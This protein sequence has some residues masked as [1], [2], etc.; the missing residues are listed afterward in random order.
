M[1]DDDRNKK[2][3]PEDLERTV[4]MPTPGGRRRSAPTRPA[5]EPATP[6]SPPPRTAPQPPMSG[7]ALAET[8]RMLGEGLGQNV[9]L[10][11]AATAFA[12][13]RHIRALRHHDDVESLRA[14]VLE[15]VKAFESKTRE[16]GA[17]PESAYAGR[18]A[19]CALIDEMVLGTPWGSDSVWNEQSLLA[20]LHNETRGGEK[21]FQ[22]LNRMS[23][24]P[25]R[26]I[27]LLELLYVCLCL[28][29]RGK[30]GVIQNGHVEL[31]QIEH[32]LY[33]TI[34]SQRGTPEA[35]LSPHWQGMQDRGG[36]VARV[37]PLWVVPVL[38]AASAVAL[39]MGIS[40][41]LNR[42]S[43]DAFARLNLI[44]REAAPR[45]AV[46]APLIPPAPVTA[47]AEPAPPT[48]PERLSAALS[49]E[50]GRGQ[51]EVM[52]DGRGA[53]IRIN[54]R[55]LFASGSARVSD[56]HRPILDKIGA[57]LDREAG[58]VF[59]IGHTDSQPI[60]TLQ[61]PSNWH[62]SSA[63]A[64]SVAEILSRGMREPGRLQPEG[65]AD[66]EPIATNETAEGREANRRIEI[67]VS[68][69]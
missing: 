41:S 55:G 26:N 57:A 12:L 50:I 45:P 32:R 62:L 51:V 59:V 19:L 39:Y 36:A 31:A 17:S 20:T 52:E 28:G 21:F 25:G 68:G 1:G 2:P 9:L 6:A 44:A 14:R 42:S 61:F 29:F 11:A 33:T 54:N 23:E 16:L 24:D 63:R 30:Y 3:P 47:T 58:P 66:Q 8:A 65:H 67:L 48:L 38:V 69:N 49:A 7:A 13:V 34:R 35:A 5:P 22:I 27:D 43:D 46:A 53:M 64:K 15:T 40:Y 18:Y 4:I 10:R 56:G 60:N 37:L